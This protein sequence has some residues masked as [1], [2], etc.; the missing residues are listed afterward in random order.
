MILTRDFMCG[1]R[2]D[3][4]ILR[5]TC[6]ICKKDSYSASVESFKPCPYCGISFSGRFGLERRS[7]YR[8]AKDD[9]LIIMKSDS[10]IE[11]NVVNVS[12]NGLRVKIDGVSYVQKG[13][14]VNV[15]INNEYRKAEILWV[16]IHPMLSS[17][18]AGLQLLQN[19]NN[20][21]VKL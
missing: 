15:E 20:K 10:K 6:P 9:P 11:A 16:N 12:N 2:D 5:L 7:E 3:R 14:I 8:I 1:K 13:D 21:L 17:A 4:M 18:Y 19:E